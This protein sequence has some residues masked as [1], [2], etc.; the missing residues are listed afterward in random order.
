M[1][2]WYLTAFNHFQINNFK[3]SMKCLKNLKIVADKL[4][5]RNKL[6]QEASN[7][8]YNEL[9]KIKIKKGELFD[10]TKVG[11]EDLDDKYQLYEQKENYLSNT[12]MNIG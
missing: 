12:K 1:E 6:I 9:M 2:I 5:V 4:K 10:A 8:L 11:N 7:E 3:A